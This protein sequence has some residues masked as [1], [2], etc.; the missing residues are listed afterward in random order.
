MYVQ[1]SDL[2]PLFP[3]ADGEV[4]TWWIDKAE[5]RLAT[6]VAQRGF[7]L[8]VLASRSP[9]LVADVVQN[10]VVR[11]LRNPEGYRSETEGDY[12]YTVNPMDSAGSIWFPDADLDVLCPR[13]L[14]FGTIGLALPLRRLVR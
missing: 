1:A 8:E 2:A 4:V 5:L 9:S 13:P 6:A 7:D 3:D 11:V 14:A 12:S 10:A